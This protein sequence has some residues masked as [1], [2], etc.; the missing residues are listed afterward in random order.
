MT[1]K[2]FAA[3]LCAAAAALTAGSSALAQ[4]PAAARPPAAA[5]AAATPQAAVHG[6]PIANMCIISVEG[7]IGGST[8]GKYVDTR[9]QQI[10]AQTNAELTGEKTAIDNDA[11]ALDARRATLDQSTLEQQASA[12]QVRANALQRKAQL[13]D[14]EVSA[15]EQKAVGRIGQ[16]MEPLIRQVYQQKNCSV[17]LQRTAVVIAN[18]AMDITPAV[19]TALNAK[20]TQFAFDRERLDQPQAAA[21]ASGAPPIVQTP[22]P[23]RPAPTKK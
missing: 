23:A 8:V 6:P 2:P 21:A 10:V 20:I 1:F 11:K 17:L 13:R 4:A 5:P 9:M 16:E 7:A 3:G 22:G 18:P 12:L 15:T 19:V 14:R